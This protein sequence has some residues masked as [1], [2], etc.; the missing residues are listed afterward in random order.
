MV[1]AVI[2]GYDYENQVFASLQ[3]FDCKSSAEQYKTKLEKDYDYV[4]IRVLEI[5]MESAIK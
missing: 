2:G 5:N 4:L 3:L 1:Y